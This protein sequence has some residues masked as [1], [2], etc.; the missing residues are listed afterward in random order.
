MLCRVMPKFGTKY[1]P[2]ALK[3]SVYPLDQASGCQENGLVADNNIPGFLVHRPIG[4]RF[5]IMKY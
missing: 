1:P 2:Q 3:F 5:I 4:Y